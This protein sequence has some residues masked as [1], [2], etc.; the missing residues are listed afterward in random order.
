[1]SPFKRHGLQNVSNVKLIGMLNYETGEIFCV[2]EDKF[3]AKVFLFFLEK[4]INHYPTGKI[5][6]ILDNSKIHHAK[7]IQPFL[8]AHKKR[9]QLVFLPPHSSQLNLNEGLWRWLKDSVIYNVFFS[10]TSEIKL[11]VRQ[12]VQHK[13]TY[14][15]QLINRLC[16]QF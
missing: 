3:D 9:L 12:F 7:L 10:S 2:K 16:V 15:Q 14:K 1:M 5:V 6:M 13:I 11:A 4:V 8:N